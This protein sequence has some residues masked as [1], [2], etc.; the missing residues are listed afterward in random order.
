M[1]CI[2]FKYLLQRKAVSRKYCPEKKKEYIDVTCW[3]KQYELEA[4]NSLFSSS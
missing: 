1:P 2:I 4:E 3:E